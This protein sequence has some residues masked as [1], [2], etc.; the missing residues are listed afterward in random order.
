M[1]DIQNGKE[2]VVVTR[3]EAAELNCDLDEITI[4]DAS[5]MY[6]NT[7]MTFECGNGHLQAIKEGEQ[8][9]LKEV[10]V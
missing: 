4:G 9:K 5:R 10:S 1:L 7:G 6:E 8:A 2:V 3:E